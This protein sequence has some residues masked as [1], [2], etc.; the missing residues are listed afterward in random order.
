[1][2]TPTLEEATPA[3]S[4]EERAE[5]RLERRINRPKIVPDRRRYRR[6][7]VSVFGRFMR[8]DKQEYPCEVINI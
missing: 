1:M 2:T 3:E 6:V 8:D 5:R 7:P 4:S